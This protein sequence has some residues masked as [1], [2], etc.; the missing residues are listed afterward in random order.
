M[1]PR[2]GK[3]V[4]LIKKEDLPLQVEDTW[5]R[6]LAE[7]SLQVRPGSSLQPGRYLLRD[8]L[9]YDRCFELGQAAAQ[10]VAL[11]DGS[12]S[13]DE[14]AH[15]VAA[16][17]QLPPE[18]VG[19]QVEQVLGFLAAR[20]MLAGRQRTWRRIRFWLNPGRV[21]RALRYVAAYRLLG[22]RT[23]PPDRPF[24]A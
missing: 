20:Q 10:I 21:W 24:T 5:A 19:P 23:Q 16:L 12:R 18:E 7:Q 2:L 14:L 4:I 1:R 17:L 22:R 9:R 3:G 13:P 6:A 15:S 11:C 8:S